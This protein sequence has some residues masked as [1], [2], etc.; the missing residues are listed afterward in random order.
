MFVH[1]C[2]FCFLQ[3][4]GAGQRGEGS[5]TGALNIGGFRPAGLERGWSKDFFRG[6]SGRLR[7][8]PLVFLRVPKQ[9]S[10]TSANRETKEA[11][12]VLILGPNPLVGT[13]S[14][15]NGYRQAMI[16]LKCRLMH[17]SRD[18]A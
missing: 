4:H 6:A 8:P 7:V 2:I 14:C 1:L 15:R 10:Y 13:L 9:P 16:Y 5:R 3:S 11:C 18:Q 12:V 17:E